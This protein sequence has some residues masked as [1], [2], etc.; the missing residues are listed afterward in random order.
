[1]IIYIHMGTQ[2]TGTTSLQ[3]LMRDHAA[4]L[5]ELRVLYPRAFRGNGA[6]HSL[7]TLSDTPVVQA[8]A[9]D[10]KKLADNSRNL[11]NEIE[12]GA[13]RAVFLS[14]ENLWPPRGLGGSLFQQ[15]CDSLS[16]QFKCALVPVVC[17]RRQDEAMRTK[18]QMQIRKNRCSDSV[19][20]F[21]EHNLGND[22][23]DYR[24]G[25][26]SLLRYFSEVLVID[27]DAQLPD[28]VGAYMTLLDVS[29]GLGI[30]NIPR[31]NISMS[32][33]MCAALTKLP[34]TISNVEYRRLAKAIRKGK[35]ESISSDAAQ[36]P[37]DIP[38]SLKNRIMAH[39]ESTNQWLINEGYLDATSPFFA[40]ARATGQTIDKADPVTVEKM[41]QAMASA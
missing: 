39:H 15:L 1:M 17:L 6:S 25:I 20:Q 11:V 4:E 41:M 14:N 24:K 8:G 13:Y 36:H 31:K 2:K 21:V 33:E 16:T 40:P 19:D 28:L 30:G 32:A 29:L 37:F 9:S 12:G 26:E 10:L 27:Y 38:L 18:R 35:L 22:R 34:P 7:N 23:Y 3:T 5:R